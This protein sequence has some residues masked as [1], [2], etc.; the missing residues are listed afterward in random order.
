M[1]DE[2]SGVA[3]IRSSIIYDITKDRRLI[4]AQT[5]PPFL[6]SM[7]GAPLE[8]TFL[9][10]LEQPDGESKQLRTTYNAKLLQLIA[11]YPVRS[12]EAE[13]VLV[14]PL[15]SRLEIASLRMHY[16]VEPRMEIKMR[17]Y[18]SAASFSEIIDRAIE[19]FTKQL[20]REFWVREKH[21]RKLARE[22][23]DMLQEMIED[24]YIKTEG[25]KQA[26][27]KDLSEGGAKLIHEREIRLESGSMQNITLLLGNDMLEVDVK[28]VRSGE[29]SPEPHPSRIFTSVQFINIQ[30]SDRTRL[31]RIIQEMMRKDLASRAG[32]A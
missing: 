11:K 8:I 31:S 6:P 23:S 10:R 1:Q 7:V 3:E 13:P 24:V 26:Y 14:V 17:A 27:I 5:S 25:I 18:W 15:P 32:L 22:L 20:R 12:G 29:L 30:K 9:C 16:R 4:L 19:D 2:S 28:I 21:P